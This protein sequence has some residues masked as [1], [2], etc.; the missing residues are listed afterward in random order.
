M[1]FLVNVVMGWSHETQELKAT[2][3]AGSPTSA[4]EAILQEVVAK[5]E[6]LRLELTETPT[7]MI[8]VWTHAQLYSLLLLQR[9]GLCL[10]RTI[11]HAALVR[12]NALL[13]SLFIST[14]FFLT[15]H[16]DAFLAVSVVPGVGCDE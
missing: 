2:L 9:Q 6:A 7:V 15:H 1:D 3:L 16:M 4:L 12:M 8:R 11:D 14:H 10:A 5:A 13:S